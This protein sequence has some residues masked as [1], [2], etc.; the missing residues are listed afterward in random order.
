[1]LAKGD[2]SLVSFDEASDHVETGRF[3][4][5]IGA[6]ESDHLTLV[7]FDR[8][9]FNNDAGAEPFAQMGRSERTAHKG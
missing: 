5:A 7:E 2:G 6:K 4:G 1:L 9:I 8:D 3:A